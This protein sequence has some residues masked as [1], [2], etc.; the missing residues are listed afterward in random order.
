MK[1][2][3][4]LWLLLLMPAAAQ[5]SARHATSDGVDLIQLEDPRRDITVS[6]APSIGNIAFEMKVK[7]KKIGRA[8]V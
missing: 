6:V 3:C 7:G 1:R 2:A 4:L 5:Y 8:H